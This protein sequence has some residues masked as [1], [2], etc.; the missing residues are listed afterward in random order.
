ML[1]IYSI[2]YLTTAYRS[3]WV[4]RVRRTGRAWLLAGAVL[5]KYGN[6]TQACVHASAIKRVL[7]AHGVTN[8][9]D[10]HWPTCPMRTQRQCVTRPR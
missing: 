4:W 10:D 6:L 3:P 9:L 2:G 7:L 8:Y 5:A 1:S